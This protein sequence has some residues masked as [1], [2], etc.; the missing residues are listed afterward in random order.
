MSNEE[1]EGWAAPA[2]APAPAPAAAPRRHHRFIA[3]LEGLR[4]RG[5]SQ[6]VFIETCKLSGVVAMGCELVQAHALHAHMLW[7][8]GAVNGRRVTT[9]EDLVRLIISAFGFALFETDEDQQ[10]LIGRGVAVVRERAQRLV[11]HLG[12]F[13]YM[14]HCYDERRM[15]AF[16]SGLTDRLIAFD[17]ARQQWRDADAA[18]ALVRLEDACRM[19]RDAAVVLDTVGQATIATMDQRMR[20]MATAFRET[21]GEARALYELRLARAQWR[22]VRVKRELTRVKR[23]LYCMWST[24]GEEMSA[25][26]A[27]Y[28]RRAED[29]RDQLRRL[30]NRHAVESDD[31]PTRHQVRLP[32]LSPEAVAF[33]DQFFLPDASSEEEDAMSPAAVVVVVAGEEGEEEKVEEEATDDDDNATLFS[34]N[35][36]CAMMMMMMPP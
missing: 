12:S 8:A 2:A 3:V 20:S 7:K 14:R 33:A 1:E 23:V 5:V 29:L 34:N 24:W 19:Q 27:T 25:E 17:A 21:K 9:E 13:N 10:P 18:H 11:V 32:L 28:A 31:N 26:M 4:Q 15:V 36:V 22:I 6:A 16:R 35:G 30:A